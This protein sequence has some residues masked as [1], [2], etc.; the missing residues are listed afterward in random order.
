MSAAA[1]PSSVPILTYHSLDESGSVISVAPTVFAE[2][3]R[4]LSE[5]GF[6]A[7]R[8]DALLDAWDGR[9]TLP[10]R[11]V[12]VTFD[13]GF[14]NVLEFGAPVLERYGFS[15][16]VFLVTDWCGKS[17]DWPGQGDGIPRLP[18]LNW[19]EVQQLVELGWE[20]AAHTANHVHL[21][22]LAPELAQEELIR[23]KEALQERLG[24]PVSS[25]AYPYGD[26]DPGVVELAREQFRGA[27][28]VRLATARRSDD[29]LQLPRLDVYYL[30]DPSLFKLLG[31]VRGSVYLG[32]RTLARSGKRLLRGGPR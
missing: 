16:T 22:Q 1:V 18:L 23:S 3:M 15:A 17:S 10:E 9:G 26:L 19:D 8:L 31:T 28:S 4:S 29:R 13:D 20:I 21:P 7:V 12:V 30:R 27:V 2:H 24:A 5:R 14:A 25:F 32:A 6:T 11:P